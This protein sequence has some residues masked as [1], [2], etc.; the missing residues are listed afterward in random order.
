MNRFWILDV[1]IEK[2]NISVWLKSRDMVI[3]KIYTYN[4]IFY[5]W[6][7]EDLYELKRSLNDLWYVKDVTTAPHTRMW[8]YTTGL[9]PTSK[10][11]VNNNLAPVLDEND[12][13]ERIDYELP[14]F[15]SV[16]LE[17]IVKNSHI[18]PRLDD[19]LD[20]IKV[21]SGD[22]KIV[23][24]G[25]N[26]ADMLISM[27]KTINKL[28]P[29]IIYTRNGDS[30]VFPYLIARASYNDVIEDISLSRDGYP[31]DKSL[32]Y[33]R[34]GGSY[35]SYGITYYTSPLQYILHGRLHINGAIG[36]RAFPWR[37]IEGIIEVA[38]V[39]MVPIQSVARITIGQAMTSMQ[40]YEAIRRDILIPRY[41]VNTS[42]KFKSGLKIIS[43]DK[44]GFIFTP[45]MG[46]FENVYELDFTSMYPTI[47]LSR[48]LSP[49]TI[50][51]SCNDGKKTVPELGYNICDKRT[52]L[53]PR[54][55]KLILDK[56]MK[57][58]QLVREF[59]KES[60]YEVRQAALKWILVTSFGYM[61]YRNARFG[62]IEAHESVTAFA[63]KIL[64]DTMH[65][66]EKYGFNIIHG[67]VDCLWIQPKNRTK[68]EDIDIENFCH[69]VKKR[70]QINLENNGKYDWIIFLPLKALPSIA[71][72]NHYYGRFEDGT[73]KIRGLALRKHDTP[74]IIKKAQKEILDVLKNAKNWHSSPNIL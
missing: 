32:I 26:E 69:E 71:T 7:G 42:E 28:D 30:F 60:K 35:Q 17:V 55:L 39:T 57:Y 34:N 24:D 4:P 51:C 73:M 37:G 40:F 59:G 46:F 29:D 52:G 21:K 61:G 6:M 31:F 68:I 15:K 54:V 10:V 66:A 45:K 12:S 72:L 18:R 47:M 49:E 58:K 44:G 67:I 1:N 64:L 20:S 33:L 13:R 14:D 11:L 41:K 23:I 50:L 38:R 36:T 19:K 53:V 27:C 22:E 8:L 63:R 5:A 74:N 65:I 3:K 9:F 2:N 62:R 48:N 56:R 16:N 43:S 70:T 25:F